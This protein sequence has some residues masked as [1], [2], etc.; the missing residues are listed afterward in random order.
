MGRLGWQCRAFKFI[1]WLGTGRCVRRAPESRVPGPLIERRRHPAQIAV[2]SE[3]AEE[4]SADAAEDTHRAWI[5]SHPGEAR[6]AVARAPLASRPFESAAPQDPSFQRRCKRMRGISIF[7]GQ[8]S[9][10]APHSVE[11]KGRVA[12]RAAEKVGTDNRSDRTRIRRVVRVSSN[13]PINRAHIETRAAAQA[14]ERLAHHRI[15]EHRTAPVIHDHDVDVRGPSSSP[16]RR[17]PL[18]KLV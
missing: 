14:T 15:G 13:P 2:A 12:G 17:G 5:A 18:I 3:G 11:A 10:Q 4:Q 9:R 7:T 1:R 6:E 8:M 16:S